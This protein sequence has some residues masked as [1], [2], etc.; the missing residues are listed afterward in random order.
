MKGIVNSKQG[1]N[2][3][4]MEMVRGFKEGVRFLLAVGGYTDL[5]KRKQVVSHERD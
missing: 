1:N 4:Q 5:E 2:H 3:F